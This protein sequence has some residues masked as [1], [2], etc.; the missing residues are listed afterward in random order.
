MSK[1]RILQILFIVISLILIILT[2]KEMRGLTQSRK[3]LEI[4]KNKSKTTFQN[5]LL[6]NIINIFEKNAKEHGVEISNFSLMKVSQKTYFKVNISEIENSSYMI[7]YDGIN[8]TE[9]YANIGI[10]TEENIKKVEDIATVL[11]KTSDSTITY[12]HAK[13]IFAMLSSNIYEENPI[14][15]LSY[16]NGLTYSLEIT[17]FGGIVINIR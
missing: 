10:I 16:T 2:V 5:E 4:S 17:E 7:A 3:N 15:T 14:T 12:E 11:I 6:E 1:K 8:V 13:R 9:I